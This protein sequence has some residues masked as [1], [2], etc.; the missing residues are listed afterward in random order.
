MRVLMYSYYLPPH[1]SGAALQALSLARK[2]RDRG[3]SVSFLTVNHGGAPEKESVE[4]FEFHR[5]SQGKG[6]LGEARLW[7]NMYA[8]AA[9]GSFDILHSHGAYLKNSFFG[10]LSRV[11]GKKSLLK[12]SLA[13]DDLHGLG[14][15]RSGWLHRRFVSMAHRYVSISREITGEMRSYGLPGEKIAEIP[16]GVDTGRFHPAADEME[17]RALRAGAGL[18]AEGRMI[19]Y[20][21]GI[22]SRK[23][24]R[25]LVES[26][27]DA[28][29][30]CPGFLV[31]VGP[32][33]REDTEKRLYDSLKAEEAGL[34]GRFFMRGFTGNIEEFYRMADVFVLP[35]RN[36]GMPNAVLEAMSSGL[37]CVAN[38][39]SG[40]GEL[41]DSSTGVLIDV[42]S[43]GA[44]EE[45]LKGLDGPR[46]E[47]LG[48]AAR[49]RILREY[50]LETIADRYMKLYSEMLGR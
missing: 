27:K 19:L 42:E 37:A 39:V 14:Q 32:V 22:S 26:W 44:L 17:K 36:E 5:V 29:R 31:V 33:A 8:C 28:S 45:A 25:W 1:Y 38:R 7:K 46:A 43:R 6:P 18:P 21:G 47:D 50:S 49:Q 40:A 12:V 41:I 15:G 23:N 10:P 16:N 34:K 9:A 2:L 11:L 24:V 4:G 20:V 13:N 35:S 30:R 48:A 3:A